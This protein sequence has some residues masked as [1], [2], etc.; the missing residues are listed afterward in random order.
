M[1]ISSQC[2]VTAPSPPEWRAESYVG[3]SEILSATEVSSEKKG[4]TEGQDRQ[5]SS[6]DR[7][8]AWTL[9]DKTRLTAPPWQGYCYL[10]VGVWVGCCPAA[11]RDAS[12][13]S[14][15]FLWRTASSLPAGD[16]CW[17]NS[18]LLPFCHTASRRGSR[19][20]WGLQP[21]PAS[22]PGLHG[23]RKLSQQNLD[24]IIKI[25]VYCDTTGE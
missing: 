11:A 6:P 7:T 5:E 16:L 4:Q 22:A 25:H 10:Q 21:P 12:A 3:A 14:P 8:Q 19:S 13:V 17:R 1:Q 18:S 15:V 2:E 24:I 20:A 9:S 23:E